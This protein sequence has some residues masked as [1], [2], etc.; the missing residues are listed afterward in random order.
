MRANSKTHPTETIDHANLVAPFSSAAKDEMEVSL[1]HRWNTIVSFSDGLLSGAKTLV[2]GR[3]EKDDILGHPNIQAS[4][5][6]RLTSDLF[7][8]FCMQNMDFLSWESKVPPPKLP[9]Q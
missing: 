3:V 4:E 5:K 9:P 2:L 7:P 6:P 8:S 1:A